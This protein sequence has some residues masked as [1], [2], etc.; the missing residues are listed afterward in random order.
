M[1]NNKDNSLGGLFAAVALVASISAVW[2]SDLTL[3]G[4]FIFIVIC[5]AIGYAVGQ[6][7]D[8]LIG[9]VIFFIGSVVLLLYNAAVRRVI[10]DFISS[11]FN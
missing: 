2:E 6:F 8:A 11:L 10:W 1:S 3:L 5:T 4:G 7:V 9:R